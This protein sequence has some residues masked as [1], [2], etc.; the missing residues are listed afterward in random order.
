MPSFSKVRR[1][2]WSAFMDEAKANRLYLAFSKKALEEGHPEVAAIFDKVAE[3]ETRH[4]LS[5][6]AA[7]GEVKSTAENLR[8]VLDLERR[9]AE[10]VFPRMLETVKRYGDPKA[11]QTIQLA[12]TEGLEHLK[13]FERALKMLEAKGE[14]PSPLPR[15]ELPRPLAG[16]GGGEGPRSAEVRG[17]RRRIASLERIRELVFGMQDGVVSTMAVA[18]SVMIAT[19]RSYP[20]VT[21]GLASGIA[22]TIAMA[23]GSYLGSKSEAELHSAELSKESRELVERPEEEVAE[24]VDLYREEGFPYEEAV[25]LADR[26]A[27]DPKLLLKTLAEKELGLNPERETQAS[28]YKDAATMGA[29]FFVGSMMTLA[30]YLLWSGIL[31][32]RASIAA[33]LALLFAIGA[34]KTLVTHRNPWSSGAEVMGIGAFSA[35]C[36]YILAKLVPAL[37]LLP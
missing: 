5:H 10:D 12:I 36:G 11:I 17:E 28:P 1:T 37:G 15:K 27:A 3:A 32:V 29:A 25:E 16:E 14:K 7:L 33:S 8:G 20:A 21:A 6:L 26:V 22:G 34:A 35:L 30:P 23:S 13:E 31:A 2:L 19:G 9:E 24:L 18:S 4:A